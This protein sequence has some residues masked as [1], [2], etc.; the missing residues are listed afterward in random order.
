M[1]GPLA[2]GAHT[3]NAKAMLIYKRFT[4]LGIIVLI[5]ETAFG[6]VGVFLISKNKARGQFSL[7]S[8]LCHPGISFWL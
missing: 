8:G 6:V 1:D 3:R 2:Y 5:F 7:V 4:I